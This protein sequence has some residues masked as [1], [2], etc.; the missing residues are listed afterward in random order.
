[1]SGRLAC[2]VGLVALALSAAAG[3]SA[4]HPPEPV[5]YPVE[6]GPIWVFRAAWDAAEE[7]LLLADPGSGTIYQ[8]DRTGRIVR[9]LQKL[10]NGPLEFRKP[11]NAMRVGERYLVRAEPYRRLWLDS[12]LR[13]RAALPFSWDEEENPEYSYLGYLNEA[14]GS[15][16]SFGFGKIGTQENE[17]SEW[18]VFALD[19][20]NPRGIERYGP[21]NPDVVEESFLSSE[22][23]KL[24]ACGDEA[25]FLRMT[26]ELRIEQL[27]RP[28]RR[29]ESFPEEF[30]RRPVLASLLSDAASSQAWRASQR[31]AQLADGL[32]C[33]EAGG[34]LLLLAHA[35][36]KEGGVDWYVY[37][38][39]IRTD[40]LLPRIELPTKAGDILFV[41]G[42]SVWAVFD[43]G[44]IV[45]HANQ[46]LTTLRTFPAPS[47]TG[48]ERGKP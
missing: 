23:S 20:E 22:P 48:L 21:V 1:M 45:A 10:G 38:I 28:G 3:R 17:W 37:P 25:Y 4:E 8:Y 46:P 12:D 7:R 42:R 31:N 13:I 35:P 19:Y 6:R 34:P 33:V 36:R 9:R 5:P 40:R 18:E 2:A 26:P 41:P 14:A 30:R 27:G 29:L 15:T 43:K 11:S 47:F 39:D 44:E 24:A 16:R 32:Y